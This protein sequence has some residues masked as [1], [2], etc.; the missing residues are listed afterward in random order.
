MFSCWSWKPTLIFKKNSSFD[1]NYVS[2]SKLKHNRANV[3]FIL[4]RQLH[5]PIQPT[6]TKEK[7]KENKDLIS[8]E[9]LKWSHMQ[10]NKN[11]P[12]LHN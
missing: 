6:E 10:K 9:I 12:V 11:C 3:F 8:S 1:Y 4:F 2:Q 5:C 7:Q